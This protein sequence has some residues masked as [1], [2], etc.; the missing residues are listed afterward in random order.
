MSETWYREIFNEEYLRLYLPS[1]TAER[2]KREVEELCGLLQLP[3][4]AK[5][6]DLCCGHGRHSVALAERGYQVTGQD[7][8][9]HFLDIA[10]TAAAERGAE[11]RWVH[12]DM[13][14]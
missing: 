9:G 7:L 13:R 2:T 6:L 5:I 10:R 4:G 12:G 1:L 14:E 3:A 8:S 11:V